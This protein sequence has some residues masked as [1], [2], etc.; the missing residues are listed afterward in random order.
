MSQLIEIFA[1]DDQSVVLQS[2][3]MALDDEGDL[4]QNIWL[5]VGTKYIMRH[6]LVAAGNIRGMYTQYTLHPVDTESPPQPGAMTFSS[7]WNSLGD[8]PNEV[9][10]TVNFILPLVSANV[11]SRDLS[12][13]KAG[14]L[15]KRVY[16][17]PLTA[18]IVVS[19]EKDVQHTFTLVDVNGFGS[20]MPRVNTY[21]PLGIN[22]CKSSPGLV[23]TPSTR[24]LT[25]DGEVEIRYKLQPLATPDHGSYL[26]CDHQIISIQSNSPPYAE[27][28]RYTLPP[29]PT[30][31]EYVDVWLALGSV[32]RVQHWL[33]SVSNIP[34]PA[35][36]TTI[37]PIDIVP[38]KTPIGTVHQVLV[39]QDIVVHEVVKLV[40]SAAD[41]LDNITKRLIKSWIV[42]QNETSFQEFPTSQTEFNFYTINSGQT[43]RWV[44]KDVNDFG[45]SPEGTIDKSFVSALVPIPEPGIIPGINFNRLP[46]PPP[47]T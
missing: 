23:Y 2:F 25:E 38:P 28:S 32:Y 5:N 34:G 3:P 13:T 35:Y 11:T 15:V 39:S 4:E 22:G 44:W 31:L 40:L 27:L 17:T 30:G 42:G 1:F 33:E 43:R 26:T 14:S 12:I 37:T 16:P 9:P 41:P 24:R 19:L 21:T 45:A 20:S 7:G 8:T 36:T 46:P 10:V 47:G 29:D 18:S 6:C